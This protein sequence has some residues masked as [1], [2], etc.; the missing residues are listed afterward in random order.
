MKPGIGLR[1][2]DLFSNNLYLGQGWFARDWSPRP[3]N[4]GG[5]SGWRYYTCACIAVGHHP[6]PT[7]SS[8]VCQHGAKL[9]LPN[10]HCEICEQKPIDL[11]WY[12]YSDA[13]GCFFAESKPSDDECANWLAD[14][15]VGGLGG[16][17]PHA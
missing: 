11:W 15:E 6:D 12:T 2:P 14:K 10:F 3:R 16:L 5:Q 1:A 13:W 8:W 7:G 17:W 9:P 4:V